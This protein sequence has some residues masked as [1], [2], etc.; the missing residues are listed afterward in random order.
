MAYVLNNKRKLASRAIDENT[1][2]KTEGAEA[3]VPYF[4]A[5]KKALLDGTEQDVYIL[6]ENKPLSTFTG[7]VIAVYHRYNEDKWIVTAD[8]NIFTDEEILLL[9]RLCP[10]TTLYGKLAKKRFVII[11]V[12]KGIYK[13]VIAL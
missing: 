9:H 4:F 11:D 8:G 10:K 5:D 13:L 6:G 12:D 2:L 3:D 1:V 7:K